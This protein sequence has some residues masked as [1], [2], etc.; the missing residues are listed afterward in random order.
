[1]TETTSSN[2]NAS[3]KDIG[4]AI[5]LFIKHVDSIG[6]IMPPMVV[7]MQEIAAR[8]RSSLHTFEG[9]HCQV[10]ESDR[11]RSVTINQEHLKRWKHLKRRYD[12]AHHAQILMP[13]SMLVSLVSQ[14]DAFLGRLL[15]IIFSL[16]PDTIKKSE[17]TLTYEQLVG[18]DSIAAARDYIIQ[19]DI[20]SIL[21]SSH[22]DQFSTLEDR[23]SLKLTSDLPSWKAFVEITERRNLFVHTD[24]VVSAQYLTNCRNHSCST[25]GLKIGD[26]LGV[27][28]EYANKAHHCILEIGIKLGQVL[29]RKLFPKAPELADRSLVDITFDL[30]DSGRFKLAISV[31]DTALKYFKFSSETCKLT[32]TIN[33]AQAYK[34]TDCE[35]DCK[36]LLQSVDW[37]A[38][39][40]AYRLANAVLHEDWLAA[41]R[42]MERIG[43]NDEIVNQTNY[44]DW[45]VF[46]QFR[47]RQEFLD[48]YRK[49]FGKDFERGIE[50]D[51]PALVASQSDDGS[52]GARISEQSTP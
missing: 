23:F 50:I 27:T 41:Q 51:L 25:E 2:E 11:G 10:E 20:E 14:F 43:T 8:F 22:P 4:S 6:N 15:W 47:E 5:E 32:S 1:M 40:D 33:L 19:K 16:K 7:A 38:K 45:P 12:N 35:S 42:L 26:R 30:L 44:R 34:W 24:G 46:R 18:F 37:E 13:R 3:T 48:T 52:E 39:G 21:R 36:S 17:R 31:L 9:A 49:V 29:W 28:Q